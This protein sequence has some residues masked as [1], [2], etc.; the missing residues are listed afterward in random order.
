MPRNDLV[1]RSAPT[2]HSGAR[3]HAWGAMGDASITAREEPGPVASGEPGGQPSHSAT[4]SRAV[5]VP[6]VERVIPWRHRIKTKLLLV[7]VVICVGGVTIFALAEGRMADQ[8]FETQA[9]GAA[10]F[11][12]TI[13]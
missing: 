11:S 6:P 8:F 1:G 12:N 10:L 9:A 13:E 5:R 4:V 2:S 3:L 7:T